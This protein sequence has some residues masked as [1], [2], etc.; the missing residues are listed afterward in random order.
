MSTKC[1]SRR[2][3]LR[4][5]GLGL[6]A[7]NLL[8][9]AAA[10]PKPNFI[11]MFADN[12]GYGDIG[13]YG[14]TKHRTPNIDRIAG[15]GMRFVSFY[16]SSGGCTPSRASLMTGC[17][18]RRVGLDYPDPDGN[19]LRPISPNGLNPDEITIASSPGVATTAS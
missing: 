13:C 16:V 8:H 2:D 5:A 19:V 3:L 9:P 17:Y 12:L 10:S 14:S 18:P 11:I 15:E 1:V 6:G 7:V 4:S